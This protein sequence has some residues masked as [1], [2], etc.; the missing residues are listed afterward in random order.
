LGNRKSRKVESIPAQQSEVID[1]RILTSQNKEV[2]R[3]DWTASDG[4]EFKVTGTGETC[5]LVSRQR[6][7]LMSIAVSIWNN[8]VSPLLNTTP[9]LQQQI[10]IPYALTR[11][12][13]EP[14]NKI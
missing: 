2:K 7:S 10:Y 4:A 5:A 14:A 11:M 8:K 3:Q 6:T 12:L 9:K 13:L 1:H